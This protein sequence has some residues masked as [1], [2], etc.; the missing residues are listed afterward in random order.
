[1]VEIDPGSQLP[2]AR[3]LHTA[4]S[5]SQDEVRHWGPKDPQGPVSN[6]PLLCC[7][8]DYSANLGQGALFVKDAR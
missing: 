1:M 7:G 4:V 6:Y 5:I 3:T 8:D 2:P